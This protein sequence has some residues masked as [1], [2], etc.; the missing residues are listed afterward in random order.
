METNLYDNDLNNLIN[1]ENYENQL[2]ERN[3]KIKK[4]LIENEQLKDDENEEIIN[5]EDI[6]SINEEINNNYEN[7]KK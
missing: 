4:N 1:K 3:W 2:S 6:I 7:E 5:L